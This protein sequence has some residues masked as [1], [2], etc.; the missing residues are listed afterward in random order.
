MIGHA[1]AAL[2]DAPDDVARRMAFGVG[3]ARELRPPLDLDGDGPSHAGDAWDLPA[4]SVELVLTN[5]MLINLASADEQ[6]AAMRRLK[7]LLAP[8]ACSSCSRTASR[9]TRA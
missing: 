9:R 7:S 1:V 4:Q 6:L 5:R 3:D 2:A 8:A